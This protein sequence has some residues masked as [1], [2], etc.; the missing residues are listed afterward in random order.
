MTPVL[1]TATRIAGDGQT[2]PLAGRHRLLRFFPN[3]STSS[4]SSFKGRTTLTQQHSIPYIDLFPTISPVQSSRGLGELLSG[5]STFRVCGNDRNGSG[6]LPLLTG[7]RRRGAID[8]PVRCCA[9][10]IF[11]EPA[12]EMFFFFSV[13]LRPTFRPIEPPAIGRR[14]KTLKNV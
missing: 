9:T 4:F 2:W 5:K 10:K 14:A 1:L 3:A 8:E 7:A 13:P 11:G 12:L 6:A